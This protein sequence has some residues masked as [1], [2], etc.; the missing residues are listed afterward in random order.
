MPSLLRARNARHIKLKGYQAARIAIWKWKGRKM[1]SMKII[2]MCIVKLPVARNR[3][4]HLSSP[5][6]NRVRKKAH[7]TTRHERRRRI[8]H[9]TSTH[10]RNDRYSDETGRRNMLWQRYQKSKLINV[11][12]KT[13]PKRHGVCWRVKRQRRPRIIVMVKYAKEGAVICLS[14]SRGIIFA[15]SSREIISPW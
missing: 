5:Y 13:K 14:A 8:S 2:I 6:Y 9:L 7:G 11:A 4:S 12:Y 1:S 10:N 3:R 15:K